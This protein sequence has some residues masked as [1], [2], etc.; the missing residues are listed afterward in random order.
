VERPEF[1]LNRPEYRR[2]RILVANEN[3][4]CGSSREGAVYALFDYGFRAVIAPSFGDIFY[5][6]CLKSGLLPV[7]LPAATVAALRSRLAA[8]PG[9]RLVVDLP[10]QSVIEADGAVHRFTLDA[11]WKEA[12][13]RGLDEIGLT[14][15]LE[16]RIAAFEER[17]RAERPWLP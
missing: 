12:L 17:Y 4:A 15:G 13:L 2:A 7:R 9:S 6:N 8:Q 5:N 10:S 3:F 14:L 1:F 16:D 11:F